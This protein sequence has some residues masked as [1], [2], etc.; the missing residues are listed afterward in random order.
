[1]EEN[2][3]KQMVLT[4]VMFNSV[5]FTNFP[6][7]VRKE[8]GETTYDLMDA[9]VADYVAEHY[10]ERVG[11]PVT[12][13]FAQLDVET[14]KQEVKAEL[15]IKSPFKTEEEAREAETML[16]KSLIEAGFFKE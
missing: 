5:M 2:N 8:D 7:Y 10:P 9:C 6:S 14:L 1:M 4:E 16:I 11:R 3:E 13:N 15:G 12:V